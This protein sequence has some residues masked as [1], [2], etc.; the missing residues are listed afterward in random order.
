MVRSR[1]Y[2]TLWYIKSWTLY[3]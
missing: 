2:D 1:T 3:N